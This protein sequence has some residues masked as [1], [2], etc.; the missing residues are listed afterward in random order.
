MADN[1]RKHEYRLDSPAGLAF[2]ISGSDSTNLEYITRG[3]YVGG[4]GDIKV[5]MAQS[6]SVIFRNALA[7]TIIPVRAVKVYSTGTDATD[8]VG[9]V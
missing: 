8:L 9:L 6:G 4:T 7:G 1:F 3:I 5:D 2:P